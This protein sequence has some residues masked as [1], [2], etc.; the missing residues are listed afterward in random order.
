MQRKLIIS[1][2]FVFVIVI[3]GGGYWLKC[4]YS[5]ITLEPAATGFDSANY[6]KIQLCE[7]CKD[8]PVSLEKAIN[9]RRSIRSF[10]KR[11][12]SIRDI[13]Q[14]LWAGQGITDAE[15]G[16][17]SAPS[18]YSVYP[19]KIYLVAN[20]VENLTSG[21]YG[22]IPESHK[23]ALLREGNYRKQMLLAVKQPSVKNAPATIII[24]AKSSV[25]DNK[26]GENSEFC[27]HAEV[28]HVGQNIY[29]QSASLN[30]GTVSIGG[31]NREVIR[32]FIPMDADEIAYYVMPLGNSN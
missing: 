3:L 15:S 13:S 16:L 6:K 23:L 17:R 14:I 21:I 2:L 20:E 10:E 9:D 26:A 25:M 4:K 5:S 27:I 30:L 7:P 24:S 18:A 31:F 32:R 29:L 11:A 8:G 12:L 19:L 28:G 22:Y 1:L